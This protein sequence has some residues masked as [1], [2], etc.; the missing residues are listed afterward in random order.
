MPEFL[1]E[2]NWK[3][4]FITCTNWVFGLL[5]G[6]NKEEINE[7]FKINIQKL[8]TLAKEN[9]CIECD[10]IRFSSCSEAEFLKLAKNCFLAFK[11]GIFNELYDLCNAYNVD[12][13]NVKKLISKDTRIGTTH[14]N[15]PGYNEKRGF[16]GTCFPKDTNSLYNQFQTS[17]TKSYLF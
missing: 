10:E 3:K 11:V 16:G 17:G 12:Y 9:G 1:T 8:F 2:A 7:T 14:M 6:E 5:E 13:E 4:D 15:V